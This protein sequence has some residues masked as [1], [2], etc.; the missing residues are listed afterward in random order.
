MA[1]SAEEV[2]SVNRGVHSEGQ[3]A[4]VRVIQR[5]KAECLQDG[6][7]R[8]LPRM[9]HLRHATHRAGCGLERDLDQITFLDRL[10]QLQEAAIHGNDL[11]FGFGTL[12]VFQLHKGRS[13]VSELNSRRAV[14]G[15]RLGEL[16]HSSAT[17]SQGLPEGQITKDRQDFIPESRLM[18]LNH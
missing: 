12:A 13:K 6:V 4:V 11:E 9:Q 14:M 7:C 15:M 1:A 8:D 10:G 2:I 17:I 3:G 16:G 5:H 18:P